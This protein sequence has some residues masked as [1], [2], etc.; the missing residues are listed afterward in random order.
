[1][2]DELNLESQSLLND[3]KLEKITGGDGGL[4]TKLCVFYDSLKCKT[5]APSIKDTCD[6]GY[7]PQGTKIL[8]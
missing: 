7:I 2:K 6:N 5:C 4:G 8:I 1:M 3:E